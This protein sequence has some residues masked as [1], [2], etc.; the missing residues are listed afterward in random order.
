MRPSEAALLAWDNLIHEKSEMR[1]K[2]HLFHDCKASSMA[3]SHS[4]KGSKKK[5]K[6]KKL[7]VGRALFLARLAEEQLLSSQWQDWQ[8]LIVYVLYCFLL[9][10]CNVCFFP[11]RPITLW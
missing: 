7:G 1:E 3:H 9:F 2:G 11:S 10:D 6:K 8:V 4:L 5:E